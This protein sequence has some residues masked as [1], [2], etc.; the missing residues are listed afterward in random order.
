MLSS[1][2][3]AVPSAFVHPFGAMKTQRSDRP[4][5]LDASFD[6]QVVRILERSCQNCHSEKTAWPLYSYLPPMSWIIERDVASGRGHMNLSRWNGYPPERQ[7]EIL[8]QMSS[9]V[10]NRVMPLPRY[11]LLHPEARLSDAEVDYLYQWAKSERK[12]LKTHTAA[13]NAAIPIGSQ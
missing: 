3:V 9:L 11:L 5:L 6:P 12:R 1:A 8:S 10:R 7:E 2:L 4:L 13:A